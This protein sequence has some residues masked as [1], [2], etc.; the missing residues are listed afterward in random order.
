MARASGAAEDAG[1]PNFKAF[2]RISGATPPK[3]L[4]DAKSG[5]VDA[6]RASTDAFLRCACLWLSEACVVAL[7]RSTYQ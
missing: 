7:G 3:I 4:P 5:F 1:V 6:K 2:C